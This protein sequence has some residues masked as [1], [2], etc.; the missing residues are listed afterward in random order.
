MTPASLVPLMA[1][2]AVVTLLAGHRPLAPPRLPAVAHPRASSGRTPTR[3]VR[4]AA[5]GAALLCLTALSPILPVVVGVGL[6][7]RVVLRRRSAERERRRSLLSE[8]PEVV[9]LLSLAVSAGLTV[10]L[11]LEVVRDRGSGTLA[12]AMGR[13]LDSTDRGASLV[14][15]IGRT[16][17]PLGEEV[18]G[19][20]RVLEAG[21]RDGSAL[22]SSLDRLADEVRTDRRRAAEER[23]RRLP[24][25]LLFPL[26]VCVLPAFGLLTVVPLLAGSLSGIQ[27]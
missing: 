12:R 20:V 19:L 23:A 16:V 8:L 21:L 26:V 7:A 1:V 4:L 11:A 13:A 3:G 22:G 17:L 15:S 5:A 27:W 10:P 14:S 18:R 24:V 2:A 9:D 25:Q 6:G